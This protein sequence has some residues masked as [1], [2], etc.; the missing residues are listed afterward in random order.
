MTRRRRTCP[1]PGV[2]K[3]APLAQRAEC[4]AVTMFELIR[5]FF[6]EWRLIVFVV[7]V[8][9]LTFLAE[10]RFGDVA[11]FIGLAVGIGVGG[12]LAWRWL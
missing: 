10:A 7:V 3:P 5:R 12:R 2:R 4:G 8:T 11:T 9:A 6:T 1:A